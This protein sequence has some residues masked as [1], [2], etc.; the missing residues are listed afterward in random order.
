MKRW[1]LLQFLLV[2][3]HNENM[4]SHHILFICQTRNVGVFLCFFCSKYLYLIAFYS[5]FNMLK[6]YV[7]PT[8]YSSLHRNNVD[9]WT[10]FIHIIHPEKY[11]GM[12]HIWQKYINRNPLICM[13]KWRLKTLSF[14]YTHNMSYII[15]NQNAKHDDFVWFC[16]MLA[17][18]K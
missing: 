15:L 4:I 13:Q 17:M 6:L 7:L 14:P 9:V 3:R 2:S 12:C 8:F 10:G 18:E 11:T 16:C 5:F 1:H